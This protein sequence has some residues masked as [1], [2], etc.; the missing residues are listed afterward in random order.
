MKSISWNCRGMLSSTA[1]QELL[2]LHGRTCADLIFISESHL[3]KNKADELRC[4]LG[5]NSMFL[6]ESDGK[7][8]GLVLFYQKENKFELN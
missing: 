7:S 2:E 1:V 4:N 5:F 6:D 3:N 8:G